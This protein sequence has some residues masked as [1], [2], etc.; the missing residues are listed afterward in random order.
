MTL[1]QRKVT[2]IGRQRASEFLWG[3]TG[4]RIF[5]A[6]FIKKDGT[7]RDMTCRRGVKAYLVGGGLLYDPKPKQLL[8]VFD[9]AIKEYRMI[10]LN[11]LISFNIGNETFVVQ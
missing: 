9:M 5:T 10:P 7:M 2:Q 4:G 6:Y 11:R 8:P 1:T 3:E